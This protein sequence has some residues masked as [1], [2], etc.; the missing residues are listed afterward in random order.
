MEHLQEELNYKLAK[1]VKR[2][3]I[4]LFFTLV[5][6][7]IM[8]TAFV[9]TERMWP[10]LAQTSGVSD[11]L[12]V[13]EVV[14]LDKNGIERVRIGSDL[15]D[16]VIDGKRVNRGEK[17]SGIMLY[18]ATGQERGGYVTFE[19][20]GNIALTLDSRKKQTALFV[21]GPDEGSALQL[22]HQNDLIEF[23]SDSDGTRLTA[24]KDGQVVMQQPAIDK[25]RPESCKAY[26]DAAPRVSAEALMQA[27]RKRFSGPACNTC[28]TQKN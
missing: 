10:A 4:A 27:C 16:A 14:I 3:E 2:L 18:D 25:M 20:S 23:R 22:W 17:V 5:G 7:G 1:R 11:S 24:V 19:P 12:R 6:L 21:S 28:L 26:K 13:R 9:I 15:P 8:T